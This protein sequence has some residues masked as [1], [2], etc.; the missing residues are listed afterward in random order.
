MAGIITTLLGNLQTAGVPTTAMPGVLSTIFSLSPNAAIQQ[1]C[2]V[3]MANSTNPEVVK[4]AATKLA[5]IP[6][7][8]ASVGAFVP[9]LQALAAAVPIN[10]LSVVMLTQAIEATTQNSNP[11][12][13]L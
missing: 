8:P 2:T 6:N 11:L 10:S 3:L 12:S 7:L 9:Q 5:E 1:I 13:F 4:D